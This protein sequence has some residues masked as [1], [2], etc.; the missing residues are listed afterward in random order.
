[1]R[2]YPSQLVRALRTIL[3]ALSLVLVALT[4]A[5]G[6]L[7]AAP[8][9]SVRTTVVPIQGT[10][11]LGLASFVDRVLSQAGEGDTI[12]FQINTHGG[13]IDAAVQIR[14]AILKSRAR[15]IAFVDKRAIS[16]G[17]LIALATNTIVMASGATMGAATP[18]EIEGGK[19]LPVE[20]KV[21]S[22]MRKEMKA[23]AEA[24]GRRGDIA[25]AMVD[26]AV[27]IEG[28]DDKDT[29][30]T[31][32]TDE[33]LRFKVADFSV[34]TVADVCAHLGLPPVSRAADLNWAERAAA[35]L[36]LPAV[37][38]LLMTL[39]MAGIM[40]ELYA[41]GHAVAG[42]LGVLALVLFFFGHHVVHLAGW[43]EILLFVCGVA[44]ILIE[45]TLFPGHGVVAGAGVLAILAA[46]ALA[47]VDT[48]TIPLDVSLSLGW[49]THAVARVFGSL[50]VTLVSVALLSRWLPR[51]R[52]GRGLILEAAIADRAT[53]RDERP[54][55][56]QAALIGAHGVAI[57]VLRPA[58]KA[59]VCGNRLD[60]VTD[61]EFIDVGA[62]IIVSAVEGA[63]VVV[64]RRLG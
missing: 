43:G 63:R 61:G 14:D 12:I 37:A 36:T 20:Q 60:V 1:M 4:G 7:Q 46:L 28:L 6:A 15:T 17:A 56:E 22:Y 53:A 5:P 24:R 2:G 11:D 51:T 54:E 45:V 10:I 26:A 58:G 9:S 50:I 48:E 29:T 44:A 33:A 32:T 40:L 23:T 52:L 64:R 59:E 35:F 57:T 27:V 55:S 19:M 25:E 34:D 62:D 18:V 21:V 13:R 47:L 8:P 42:T 49:V 30:L 16:A 41:P 39:G 3:I 31:L 38:S